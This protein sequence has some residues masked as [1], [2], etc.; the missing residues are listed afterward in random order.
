MSKRKMNISDTSAKSQKL[1][2]WIGALPE[3]AQALLKAWNSD[4]VVKFTSHE[5][6]KN[7][8]AQLRQ[9]SKELSV[10]DPLSPSADSELATVC[11]KLLEILAESC[12]EIQNIVLQSVTDA[13]RDSLIEVGSAQFKAAIGTYMEVL[14]YSHELTRRTAGETIDMPTLIENIAKRGQ[15]RHTSNNYPRQPSMEEA[16]SHGKKNWEHKDRVLAVLEE[17]RKFSPAERLRLQ[18]EFERVE[19]EDYHRLIFGNLSV[20]PTVEGLQNWLTE[21]RGSRCPEYGVPFT[22]KAIQH[23]CSK[24][25]V[26]LALEDTE[27]NKLVGCRIQARIRNDRQ[28]SEQFVFIPPGRGKA[29]LS[30]PSTLP[31]LTV[32]PK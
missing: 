1:P 23:F 13:R 27:T 30:Q 17:V 4:L 14:R 16:I 24:L 10:V 22:A 7:V 26:L 9:L 11:D 6:Y 15:N 12:P 20:P 32:I 29:P 28:G 31:A 18:K 25:G 8:E 21:H 3:F 19:I 2:E 5:S